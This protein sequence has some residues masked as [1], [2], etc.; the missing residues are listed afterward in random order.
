MKTV[1]KTQYTVENASVQE[2]GIKYNN[3]DQYVG[4]FKEGQRCN[5]G[6]YIFSNKDKYDGL[7]SRGLP[8]GSGSFSFSSGKSEYTGE[9]KRGLPTGH[10]TFF[11]KNEVNATRN[12]PETI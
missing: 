8:E 3:G 2:I 9:F 11:K 4:G 6:K 7:W 10:G 1:H 12:P 5:S